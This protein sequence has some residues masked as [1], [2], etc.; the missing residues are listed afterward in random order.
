[1]LEKAEQAAGQLTHEGERASA[2]VYIKT[3]K[4]VVEKGDDFIESE[5]SRVDKLRSGK[6]SDKKKEQLHERLNILT[7]FQ[8]AMRDEL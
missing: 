7:T 3:M 8:T 6:V 1:M 5:V 2:D 4:K